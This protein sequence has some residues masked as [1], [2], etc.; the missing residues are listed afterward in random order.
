MG[1]DFSHTE[2]HWAYG[3]F[4]RFRTALAKHEGIDLD[5]MEGFGGDMP[6]APVATP[7]KPLL[8]DSDCDGE[9]SPEDCATVAPRLREVINAV[10]PGDCHDRHDGLA[11]ADGMEAAAEAG[12]PFEFC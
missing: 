5:Q 4:G 9:I 6:W 10:W 8:D 11:L 12:E 1:V 7:L 3:G 2:A